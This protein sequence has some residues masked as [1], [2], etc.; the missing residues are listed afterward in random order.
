MTSYLGFDVLE[1][2]YNRLGPIEEKSRR[3]FVLL[4]GRTGKRTAVEVAASP[5]AIRPFTWTAFGRAEIAE[6]RE[7]L[8]ARKGRAVPFWLPSYQW[9]LTLAEDLLTLAEGVTI[10]WVR[11]TQQMF[12]TTGA[13]RHLAIWTHG[14]PGAMDYYRIAGADDPGTGV[15]ESLTIDP[16]AVA[17]YDAATGVLSF[18]KFGRLDTD[19]VTIAYPDTEHAEA[20]IS[21]QELPREAPTEG[22]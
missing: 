11:Y 4:D 15:T 8:E 10:E 6:M 21:F 18:L 2:D 19:R 22:A 17:D 7:F 12:G 13:R 5:A 16:G 1:L 14:I 9:D 3:D 20:V